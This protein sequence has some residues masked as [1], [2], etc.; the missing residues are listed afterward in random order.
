MRS[1]G[2]R[3]GRFEEEGHCWLLGAVEGRRQRRQKGQRQKTATSPSRVRICRAPRPNKSR[4]NQMPDGA[5][6]FSA[7]IS[8]P[9]SSSPKTP[10]KTTKRP[11]S[12]S[13]SSPTK[14]STALCKRNGPTRPR[15]PRRTNGP[16]STP[17][18]PPAPAARWIPARC[19]T[20]S[21]TSCSNTRIRASTPR[22]P[23][24]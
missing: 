21:R 12:S 19:A 13:T 5:S 10:G 4:S 22:S 20:R 8:K 23:R 24:N 18:P 16:T 9:T 2:E 15:A 14:P 11:R 3:D 6:A 1:S 7:S 17:S